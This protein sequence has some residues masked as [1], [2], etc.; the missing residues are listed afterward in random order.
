MVEEAKLVRTENGL[1]PEG[2]G[3]FVL[4]ARDAVWGEAERFGRWVRFEGEPRF[5]HLGLNIHVLEP[6]QP[7]CH[8]HRESLQE[9]FLVLSGRCKV[10]I[11]EQERE[12]GPWDYVHCP[13]G[14]N[15]VFVG[16]DEGPCAILMVG[17]R[18]AEG[19]TITYPVSALARAHGAGV[20]TE[21]DDPR[22]SYANTG[23]R[24]LI[25]APSDWPLA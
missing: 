24:R 21:T 23:E 20:A 11:E 1:V 6:G 2:P 25:P 19:A 5:E 12:L 3:W 17:A 16:G 7:A 13:P 14:T 15:H 22:V 4:N 8:Y 18:Q 10:L 9:G